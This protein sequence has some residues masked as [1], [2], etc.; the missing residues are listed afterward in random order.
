MVN[1]S[2]ELLNLINLVWEVLRFW[3]DS[4]SWVWFCKLLVNVKFM[5]NWVRLLVMVVV[6]VMCFKDFCISVFCMFM[7]NIFK[8]LVI[9]NGKLL[10]DLW[11]GGF[12]VMV[13]IVNSNKIKVFK[14]IK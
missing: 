7:E 6:G 11:W 2:K 4:C 14:L 3:R 9:N 13:L 1:L 10:I 8:E 12:K 5:V